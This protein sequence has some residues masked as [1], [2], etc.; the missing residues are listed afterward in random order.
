VWIPGSYLVREFAKSLQKLTAFQG[1]KQIEA[2][3]ADKCSWQIDCDS[4][5]PLVITYQVFAHDNSVR[6]AWLD[7][8]R[9]FFNGTSLCLRVEG[10]EDTTHTLEIQPLTKPLSTKHDW[11]V[12]TG[13]TPLKVNKQ[14]FGTYSFTNYDEMVDCPFELRCVA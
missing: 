5:K 10:Q 6:T 1:K 4:T 3:Q 14:G 9:G 13:A 8:S 11:K 12:A 7:D 2:I